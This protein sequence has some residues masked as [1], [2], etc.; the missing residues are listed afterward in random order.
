MEH[1]KST[2]AWVVLKCLMGEGEGQE[3]KQEYCKYEESKIEF[4]LLAHI[5]LL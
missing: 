5:M 1:K 4:S 3:A 2:T